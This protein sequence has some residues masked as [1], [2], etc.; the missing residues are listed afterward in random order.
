MNRKF[1]YIHCICWDLA[2]SWCSVALC[3]EWFKVDLVLNPVKHNFL[4]QFAAPAG[5]GY[6][7]TDGSI[8]T[9]RKYSPRS[10][11]LE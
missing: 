4:L 2:N 6:F 7:L 8:L 5:T 3:N 10:K 9:C 11:A 1:F